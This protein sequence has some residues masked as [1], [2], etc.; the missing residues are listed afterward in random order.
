MRSLPP[1]ENRLGF[2]GEAE[3]FIVYDVDSGKIAG[4][5]LGA[6]EHY[7]LLEKYP[8]EARLLIKA[9]VRTMKGKM[10][11]AE[12]DIVSVK[13]K[14]LLDSLVS[15]VM[16]AYNAEAYIAGSIDTVLAQSFA[17]IELI[18]AVYEDEAWTPYILSYADTICYMNEHLYE[19]DRIIRS[20]TA[21]DRLLG[22]PIEERLKDYR[23]IILFLFE[24]GNP[25]KKNLL[26][27]LAQMYVRVYVSYYSYPKYKELKEMVDYM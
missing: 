27:R 10:I 13:E 3:G 12:S 2:Q 7:L 1:F 18:A 14:H 20:A 26:K 4:E 9:Y 11:I 5:A 24:N 19:F 8:K 17:D 22:R 6:L 15:L 21:G 25:E 16:S 23:D